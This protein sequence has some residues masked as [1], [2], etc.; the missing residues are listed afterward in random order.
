MNVVEMKELQELVR[1]VLLER[2]VLV[3]HVLWIIV[4]REKPPLLTTDRSF[5]IYAFFRLETEDECKL[6]RALSYFL[7]NDRQIRMHMGER[8]CVTFFLYPRLEKKPGAP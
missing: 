3:P 1:Q 8:E 5:T 7:S 4:Q 2:P 6:W